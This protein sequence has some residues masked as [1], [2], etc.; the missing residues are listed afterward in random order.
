MSSENNNSDL[1]IKGD[2]F[3]R[4]ATNTQTVSKANEYS[5]KLNENNNSNDK[6]KKS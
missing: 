6:E 1:R 5:K 4:R 3:K 2:S